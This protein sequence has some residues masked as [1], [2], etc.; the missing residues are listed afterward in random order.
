MMLLA[1]LSACQKD[2]NEPAPGERPDERL[3]KALSD[4]K[5]QLVGAPYGWKAILYPGA[6]GTYSFLLKFNENDRVSMYADISSGT[7]GTAYESTYRLRAMQQPAL[8]FD[9][10][11]YLHILADPDPDTYGGIT[12][13]GLYSDFEFTID[14]VD[15]G[16]VRLTGN[17]QKSKMVLVKATQ[18]EFDAYNAGKLKTVMD[19]SSAYLKA[20]PFIYLQT[21]NGP[22]L[23]VNINSITKTFSLVYLENG[24]VKI[25]STSFSYSPRGLVLDPPLNIGG[26]AIQE[27]RWDS[28]QKVFYIEVNGAR[29]DVQSSPTYIIPLHYF[30][31][32]SFNKI[33][34]PPQEIPGWSVDFT[35]R[36]K[37]A[38]SAI[39]NGRYGLTLYYIDFTFNTQNQ[40]MD[41]YTYVIQNNQLYL[42]LFP[43][44]YTKTATGVYK[45]TAIAP[46]GNAQLI[47]ADMQPVLSY[48]GTDNFTLDY[49]QD[50]A[51]GTLGQVKSIQHPDFYFTGFLEE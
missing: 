41:V 16:S 4:Y 51:L 9:T 50:Q 13:Q 24:S 32:V 43:Y 35:N 23:Q 6:G 15:A 45:F 10:Y 38:A 25:I 27:L 33:S 40:T 1:L 29:I 2:D 5:T 47:A 28:T 11:S 39:L 18:E 30:V 36:W 19:E 22:K 8:L 44:N 3:S 20:N 42:A 34:V 48:I 26:S 17:L 14:S 12:G 46:N 31:G 21:T 37:Q 49:F 7:A